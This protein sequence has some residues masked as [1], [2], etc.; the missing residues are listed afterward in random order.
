[1]K[2]FTDARNYSKRTALQKRLPNEKFDDLSNPVFKQNKSGFLTQRPLEWMKAIEDYAEN[3]TD[4]NT[5]WT[6]KADEGGMIHEC[7]IATWSDITTEVKLTVFI[8]T[9]VV[10]VHGQEHRKYVETEFMQSLPATH[11]TLCFIKLVG[12][13]KSKHRHIKEVL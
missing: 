1:M 6:Y 5:R 10:I 13:T 3:E 12:A 4:V 8:S 7:D 9:G 11:L 2:I